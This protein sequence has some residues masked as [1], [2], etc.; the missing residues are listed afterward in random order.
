MRCDKQ[1]KQNEKSLKAIATET[2]RINFM[3]ARC[4]RVFFLVGKQNLCAGHRI[5]VADRNIPSL[6]TAMLLKRC[7]FIGRQNELI[8]TQCI[9]HKMTDGDDRDEQ[10][11]AIFKL[12]VLSVICMTKTKTSRK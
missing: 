12:G 6:K 2:M 1:N 8:R 9:A 5:Y 10:L 3:Y 7:H 11:V 4:S